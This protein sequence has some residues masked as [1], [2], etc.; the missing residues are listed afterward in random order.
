MH[1][2][3]HDYITDCSPDDR[4]LVSSVDMY[5]KMPVSGQTVLTRLNVHFIITVR[6]GCCITAD[7][8]TCTRKSNALDKQVELKTIRFSQRDC[9]DINALIVKELKCSILQSNSLL[10]Q[11]QHNVP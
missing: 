5:Q 6:F 9:L 4:C 1:F 7:A 2:L 11:Q 3:L 10:I 8:V